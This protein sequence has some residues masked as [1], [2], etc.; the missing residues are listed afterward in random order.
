[1][2]L[3]TGQYCMPKEGVGL[4]PPTELLSSNEIVKL[5][6]LF[7]SQGVTKVRL[8]GGEPLVRRDLVDIIRKCSEA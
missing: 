4:T 7:A 2:C 5:T 6:T 1:M 8:T 3:C